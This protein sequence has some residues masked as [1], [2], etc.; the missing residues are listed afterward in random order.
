MFNRREVLLA[1]WGQ[2]SFENARRARDDFF[3]DQNNRK[4]YNGYLAALLDPEIWSRLAA[5]EKNLRQ[6]IERRAELRSAISAYDRIK[7]A[8][9]ELGKI[10][11]RYDYLEQERRSAI[12]G[13]RS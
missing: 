8:D 10:A 2:R 6:A 7:K 5:R 3:R 4:R 9:M 11:A 1:A 12:V 13:Y